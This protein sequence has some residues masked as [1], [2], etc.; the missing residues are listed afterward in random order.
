MFLNAKISLLTFF[1]LKGRQVNEPG[2][3][4]HFSL[5]TLGGKQPELVKESLKIM[6]I[7]IK[8]VDLLN[9]L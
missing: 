7:I 6:Q 8:N 5:N 4:C 1:K 3:Q 9:Q 2:Q